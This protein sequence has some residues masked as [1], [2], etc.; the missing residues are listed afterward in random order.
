MDNG[1]LNMIF[2]DGVRLAIEKNDDNMLIF[3]DLSTIEAGEFELLGNAKRRQ[4]RLTTL[5]I[6]HQILGVK[7]SLYHLSNGQ[8]AL[9]ESSV[10]ISISHTGDGVGGVALHSSKAVGLDIEHKNRNFERVAKRFLSTHERHYLTNNEQYGI[11]W[12]AKEAA[13]KRLGIEAIDFA[14]HLQIDAFDAHHDN[15]IIVHCTHPQAKRVLTLKKIEWQDC[16]V[17]IA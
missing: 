5:H 15:E 4:E 11:A 2:A 16:L 13:Y 6:L 1:Q 3:N 12:C 10:N 8:P 9:Q 17:L 14:E 7:E